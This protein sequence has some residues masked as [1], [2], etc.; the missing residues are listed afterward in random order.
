M[1]NGDQIKTLGL[2]ENDVASSYRAASY[3]LTIGKI[4]VPG[5][6]RP[7]E[8]DEFIIPPQGMVEV[9]SAERVKLPANIAGYTT[10]RNGLSSKGILAIS[11][12]II[13]PLYQG[14]MSSTLINFS[15]SPVSLSTG[16]FF[17]RT[18]F[19]EYSPKRDL[20]PPKLISD[21]DY[22][23]ER[24]RKVEDRFSE[25]FLDLKNTV[26]A[27]TPGILEEVFERWKKRLFVWMPVIALSLAV[28]ALLVNSGSAFISGI[29]SHRDQIKAE[30]RKEIQQDDYLQI[31]RELDDLRQQLEN[32]IDR[33]QPAIPSS[34]H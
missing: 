7:K 30:L 14:L 26:A 28:T 18:T 4:I 31:K 29:G 22:R 24:C 13:D 3:D 21:A 8:Y 15:R 33:T 6:G 2:I 9:I 12:G 20:A 5:E 10:L 16:L 32:K 17:L 25:T 19:H 11:V 1:L 34:K 23:S 27:V